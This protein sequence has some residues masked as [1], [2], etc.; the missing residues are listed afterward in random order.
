MKYVGMNME[1][2]IEQQWHQRLN[3]AITWSE[4]NWLH[5]NR[6]VSEL[7]K[8]S[9]HSRAA[10]VGEKSGADLMRS[11]RT[12]LNWIHVLQVKVLPERLEQRRLAPKQHLARRESLTS[13]LTRKR[14][15]S[16][17]RHHIWS[18]H[19]HGWE[20]TCVQSSAFLLQ[21]NQG[22]KFKRPD[23]TSGTESKAATHPTGFGSDVGPTGKH[24]QVTQLGSCARSQWQA[25]GYV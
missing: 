16:L 25:M 21:A 8:L 6:Q 17:R 2:H 7:L 10:K 5:W 4:H 13:S 9:P 14:D 1:A 18:D 23:S 11:L 15:T 20:E 3:N 22:I 19:I 12:E 24:V